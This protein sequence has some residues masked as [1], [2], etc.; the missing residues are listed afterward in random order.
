MYKVLFIDK[1]TEEVLINKSFAE[2]NKAEE[3]KDR[4]G[5]YA[6]PKRAEIKIE[7]PKVEKR[8]KIC[9]KKTEE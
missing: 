2:E 9:L 4:I 1:E 8:R 3:F 7:R 5:K 6:D